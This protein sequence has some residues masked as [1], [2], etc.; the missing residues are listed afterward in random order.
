MTGLLDGVNMAKVMFGERAFHVAMNL[1]VQ[2][3]HGEGGGIASGVFQASKGHEALT[4]GSKRSHLLILGDLYYRPHMVVASDAFRGSGIEHLFTNG[5][6]D[7]ERWLEGGDVVLP[8]LR[9]TAGLE[10]RVR[11]RG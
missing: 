10:E 8:P 11:R 3:Y 7:P 2:N 4:F 9:G 1:L 5:F 6:G